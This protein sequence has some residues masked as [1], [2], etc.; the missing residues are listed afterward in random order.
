MEQQPNAQHESAAIHPFKNA[1]TTQFPHLIKFLTHKW[2]ILTCLFIAFIPVLLICI[3]AMPAFSTIDDAIQT[4]YPEGVYYGQT[5][6]LMLYTLAPISVPLGMLGK[7]FPCLPMFALCQLLFIVLSTATMLYL[8]SKATDRPSIRIAHTVLLIACESFLTTYLTYTAVA[9]VVTAS[10]LSL[11]VVNALSKQI[12]RITKQDIAGFFLV[13]LGT[14]LRPESGF[15]TFVLFVPFILWVLIHERHLPSILRGIAAGIAA[16]L[17]YAI[18][19]AAYL[20]TPGWQQLPHALKIGRAITDTQSVDADTIQAVAPNLSN[21]DVDMLYAWW[22]GDKSVFSLDTFQKISAFVQEYS[23]SNILLIGKRNLLLTVMAIISLSLLAA[24]ISLNMTRFVRSVVI[25]Q[26]SIILCVIAT[27]LALALRN[28]M[29]DRVTFSLDIIALY[30]LLTASYSF[31]DKPTQVTTPARRNITSS[32]RLPSF[33]TVLLSVICI[34]LAFAFPVNHAESIKADAAET[35]IIQDNIRQYASNHPEQIFILNVVCDE[36]YV[37]SHSIFETF[38]TCRYEDNTIPRGGWETF[39]A[40]D[41]YIL[42]RHNLDKDHRYGNLI[43]RSD[44]RLIGDKIAADR[45]LIFLREHYDSNVT[46]TK[47]TSLT[48]NDDPNNSIGV[49]RYSKTANGQ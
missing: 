31:A 16:I 21:N 2:N 26:T 13:F 23:L 45:M 27:L 29:F 15:A 5:P 7:L 17:A 39:A 38:K 22:F 47:E 6:Y 46:V 19:M 43:N 41:D 3:F 1:N 42:S 11:L 30:A 36:A 40:P 20:L 10:G 49:Y 34:V 35:S 12:P 28:R 33:F 14:S 44:V 37:K 9:F 8:A 4:M 25:L 32:R 24:F 48:D 18:G